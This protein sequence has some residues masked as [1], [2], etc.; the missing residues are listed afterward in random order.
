MEA[1]K[2]DI[3]KLTIVCGKESQR[4]NYPV[5]FHCF[6]KSCMECDVPG[7]T[8]IHKSTTQQV[9]RKLNDNNTCTC[10][11]KF[12]RWINFHAFC[13]LVC[14]HENINHKNLSA[15][16]LRT[17][18]ATYLQ[19]FRGASNLTIS[20]NNSRKKI[21]TY[22]IAGKVELHYWAEHISIANTTEAKLMS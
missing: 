22:T 7:H 2:N 5:S 11:V 9:R 3:Y 16:G 4:G 18:H 6:W 14:I 1:T 15:T 19:I 8:Q 20:Q 10:T 21:S 13:K 17:R 12:S